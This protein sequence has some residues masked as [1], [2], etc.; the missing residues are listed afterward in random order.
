VLPAGVRER[1]GLTK[2]T[3]LALLETQDG[4]VMMPRDKMRDFVRRHLDGVDLVSEL[5]AER[6]EAAALD[7]AAS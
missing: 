3:V 4:I 2:G 7:D 6:R 1:A 5:L